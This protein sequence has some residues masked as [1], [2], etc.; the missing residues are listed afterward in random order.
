LRLED[1][2]R[3]NHIGLAIRGAQV[4]TFDEVCA[5]H[6]FQRKTHVVVPNFM[7]VPF[8]VA[9]TDNIATMPRRLLRFGPAQLDLQILPLPLEFPK[10]TIRQFWP[11]R[12]HQDP[13]C[14]WLRDE[15]YKI[16]QRL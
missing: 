8:I 1:Y 15:V 13:V 5:S 11:E 9:A 10:P 16:C 3:A 14:R 2:Q 7:S 12:N 6:G 4:S